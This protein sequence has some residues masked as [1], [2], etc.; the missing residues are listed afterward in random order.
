MGS[1]IVLKEELE[2]LKFF[3]PA[4][5]LMIMPPRKKPDKKRLIRMQKSCLEKDVDTEAVWRPA[6]LDS[7]HLPYDT[8]FSYFLSHSVVSR[9][10]VQNKKKKLLQWFEY[11]L[12]VGDVSSL[13]SASVLCGVGQDPSALIPDE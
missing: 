1:F 9:C 7:F 11:W 10:I 6:F 3:A 2:V 13:T 8:H 4:G 12:I 5:Y